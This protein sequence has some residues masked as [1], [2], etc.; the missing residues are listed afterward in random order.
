MIMC[1]IT[2]CHAASIISISFNPHARKGRDA[3]AQN[4]TLTT[5]EPSGVIY[6]TTDGTIPSATN[7]TLYST[8]IT[9]AKPSNKCIKAVTTKAG[10]TRSDILE[11][12]ITVTA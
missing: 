6:Y 7:G 1:I 5:T 9:C 2:S 8:A 10:K 11:L 4:V 3:A 12:Y